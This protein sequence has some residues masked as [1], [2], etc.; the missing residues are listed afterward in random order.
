[1]KLLAPFIAWLE[2]RTRFRDRPLLWQ[3]AAAPVLML[4][5]FLISVA[6][7]VATLIYAQHGTSRVVRD[8]MHKV[9]TLTAISQRFDHANGE[10]YRL[11]T[12]KAAAMPGVDV[13]KRSSAIEADLRRARSDLALFRTTAPDDEHARLDAT[14]AEMDKYI[15]AINVVASML[16]VN[17]SA[18]AAMLAPFQANAHKVI[19]QVDAVASRGVADAE[20]HSAW[21]RTG[22]TIMI[23]VVILA[24]L[25]F[26]AIGVI[27]PLAIGQSLIVPI[28]RIAEATSA[29]ARRDYG[30]DLDGLARGDELGQVVEAL[31]TFRGQAIEKERLERAAHEQ[32]RGRAKAVAA[33]TAE[34]ERLRRVTLD[35]LLHQFET[36]VAVMIDEARKSMERLERNVERVG[37][38]AQD[39]RELAAELDGSAAVFASEMA[40]AESATSELIAGIRAIDGQVETSSLIVSRILDH[41]ARAG[42]EVGQ[43]VARAA[44]AEKVVDVIGDIAAQT[45]LLALNATIEAARSGE[46]GKGFAVVATEIKSLSGRTGASTSEVRQ[47]VG[48]VQGGIRRVAD[49]TAELAALIDQMSGVT[50]QVASVSRDQALSTEMI[51]SKIAAVL[52]RARALSQTGADI[53][54][55]AAENEA[56]VQDLRADGRALEQALQ[57]LRTD[58][59]GF[60]AR[61]RAA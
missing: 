59:Q 32:E 21:V 42:D 5:L 51:N 4:G 12:D 11:I 61:L 28:L 22:I 34:G 25:L 35:Q 45:N 54:A 33:A 60:V 26:A 16:D 58:A 47:R 43:S 13:A 6:L 31:K 15:E 36:N 29:L 57:S 27:G 56:C 9:A 8:D 14:L 39:S 40:A 37:R 38:A 18:S 46:Q 44:E 10:L 24:A 41:A 19:Q 30:V 17:F 52:D 20:R 53:S 7:S 2:A 55:S 3:F 1:V 50:R 48:E 23:V 49:A